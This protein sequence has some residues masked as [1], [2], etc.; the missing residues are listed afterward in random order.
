[1]DQIGDEDV[2]VELGITRPAGPMTEGGTDETIGFQQLL[3]A[4]T[5]PDEAGF[6]RQVVEHG[7]DGPVVDDR[8]S[9]PGVIRSEHPQQRDALRCR[10]GQVVA[11]AAVGR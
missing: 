11:G 4:S 6:C 8:D 7:A 10:E 1:L 5:S 2:G 3:S 9:V